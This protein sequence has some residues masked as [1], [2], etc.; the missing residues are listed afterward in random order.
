MVVLTAL[1]GT[2]CLNGEWAGGSG[3][4]YVFAACLQGCV[5][6]PCGLLT[7][8]HIFLPCLGTCPLATCQCC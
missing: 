3:R 2:H 8:G 4:W 6:A 1:P 7:D 5:Q